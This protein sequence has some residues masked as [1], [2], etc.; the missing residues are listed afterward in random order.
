M[1]ASCRTCCASWWQGEG[2]DEVRQLS[3]LLLALAAGGC[4]FWYKPVP[5][6]NAIGEERTLL[7]GDSVHVFRG[8][9]FEVYGPNAESV[10]DGYEQL[11]RAYRAFDRYFGGPSRK[12]AFVLERDSVAPLDSA[13]VRSFRDRQFT[14]VQYVRPR[15]MRTRPRYGGIDYGGILW[16]I[17]PSAA[18]QLL[19]EFAR[20]QAGTAGVTLSDS[21]LLDRF[22]LWYRAGV[23]RLAGDV[24]SPMKDLERVRDKR[25]VLI[26]FRDMLPLVR[27]SANDTL[28]DPSRSSDA[29]EYTATLAAQ[30]G[31]LV[32]YLVER[33]GPA[34]I[35]RL[36]RGYAS[37][38]RLDDMM[39]E[40]TSAPRTVPEL[41]RRW[42]LWID[43]RE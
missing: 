12:L 28:I 23:M 31:M 26:P 35:G 25:D 9:R 5:V 27:S 2:V 3:F 38:R 15:G 14:V 4:R 21:A 43:T 30:A 33:E 41:E 1:A 34:I 39:A 8:P 40:F 6:A 11:N 42:L 24:A 20:T 7:A 18:R 22:P 37:G 10:Y 17:A 32:R 36:G 16:P 19:A 29:D 13:V